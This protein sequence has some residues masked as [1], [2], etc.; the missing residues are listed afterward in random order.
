MKANIK[1]IILLTAALLFL[2]T[3]I[4][5]AHDSYRKPPGNAYGHYKPK[6]HPV[7]QHKHQKV[8]WR[9]DRECE[10]R[11]VHEHYRHYDNYRHGNR[12]EGSVFKFSVA[13]P[14]VAFKI[15]VR[16]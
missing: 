8:Q 13:D 2:G 16:D 9:N 3:G 15:V 6:G 10:P 1:N 7:W 4:S 14:N 11:R 5:F 12:Y